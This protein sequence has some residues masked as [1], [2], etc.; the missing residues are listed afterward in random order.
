M[1]I[2]LTNDESASASLP[3]LLRNKCIPSQR[4]LKRI[5]FFLAGISIGTWLRS[6]AY[7]NQLHQLSGV[8]GGY[9]GSG[10]TSSNNNFHND[11]KTT[12]R[13]FNGG[14]NNIAK[15]TK[16]EEDSPAVAAGG[17][18]ISANN[19]SIS[20]PTIDQYS[21]QNVHIVFST[22]CSGYQ[23]WQS[24]VLYYSL[25]RSGHLG[26]VTRVVSGCDSSAKEE[27]IRKELQ[28]MMNSTTT[29][30]PLN[31]KHGQMRIHFTPSF[32]LPGKHYKYSNKPGGL[33]HWITHTTIHEPVITLIDPDMMLLRP[34]TPQL[35]KD[36]TMVQSLPKSR[37]MEYV[38]QNNRIQLLRQS[39]L[40]PL[41]PSSVISPGIAAGQHFGIGGFW[42]SAGTKGA[43]KDFRDFNLTAVC[44]VNS[45]CLN[46]ASAQNEQTHYTT[47]EQA[48]N[49]YAVGPIYI[50]ST[51]DWKT[52]ILPRWSEFTPR[53][54]AQYPKLLAEMYAFTMAAAD[55][56]LEFALSSSY[57][58][59]D[60]KTMST[61][62]GWL[63]ID[64]Y[65]TNLDKGGG[66]MRSVCEGAAFNSLPT[67]TLRR[68]GNYGYGHYQASTLTDDSAGPLPTTLHY[69]QAYKFA[70]HTFAKRKMPH[71][72][73]RCNGIPLELDVDAI[74]HELDL[75]EVKEGVSENQKKVQM[76]TAFMLCH[77]IPLMNMALEEYKLDVCAIQK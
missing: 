40:P 19:K 34:I 22:D 49:H 11:I 8:G 43:R 68:L 63:W 24:I 77:L 41:P 5:V 47:R 58:V 35:G 17:Y 44:G 61:T 6:I 54:H 10:G 56:Q 70:N 62:E 30:N 57:M 69:C 12:K 15:I 48:D 55:A 31:Q 13:K 2:I 18:S 65:Q 14:Q 51:S 66:G 37:M 60:P 20:P 27:E 59:S 32:A 38:D 53:V 76:R 52:L 28:S 25:R 39:N 23:H 46:H 64:E 29:K 45:A 21:S 36:V 42:A 7:L 3:A 74:M 75:M 1:N 50:A 9:Y 72:F 71:D 26:P 4:T 33:H 73:F 67:E 16:E